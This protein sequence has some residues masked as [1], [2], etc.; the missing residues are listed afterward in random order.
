MA[1]RGGFSFG[2]MLARMVAGVL[3]VLVTYNPTG[4]SYVEW[5]L[6]RGEG[7]APLLAL[8]GVCLLILYVIFVRS[9][10]RAIGVFGVLLAS[11]F[12][13]ALLWVLVDAGVLRLD[14]ASATQWAAL[15][16]LGVVLGIGLSW[17]H[18]RRALS[19]QAD[20]DDVDD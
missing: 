11:A 15:T 18:V 19:G 20:V 12:V 17:S 5:L 8:A 14:A 9:T 7:E 2:D 4:W 6:T 13:A 1:A 16:G 3:L 10:L